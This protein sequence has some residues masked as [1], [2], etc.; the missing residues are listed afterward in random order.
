MT[1]HKQSDDVV[2][3]DN[4]APA[5]NPPGELV[6]HFDVRIGAGDA[7]G[8]TFGSY[9]MAYRFAR[10][11]AERAGVSVWLEKASGG[12]LVATFRR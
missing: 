4:S 2:I 5:Q 8:R 6:L 11:V 1:V 10:D 9:D 12:E 3:I 7:E